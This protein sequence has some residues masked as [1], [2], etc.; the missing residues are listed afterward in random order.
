MF[1]FLL[2]N[3][4]RKNLLS[5]KTLKPEGGYMSMPV[6]IFVYGGAWGSGDKNMYGPLCVEIANRLNAVVCCPNLSIYL[7]LF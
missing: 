5:F 2:L 6:V 3:N 7:P 4:L 1:C